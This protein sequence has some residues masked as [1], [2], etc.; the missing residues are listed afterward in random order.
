MALY[1]FM[2]AG[3]LQSITHGNSGL[4]PFIC[5]LRVAAKA[6]DWAKN[7]F[8]RRGSGGLVDLTG[9]TP[10][11]PSGDELILSIQ[12]ELSEGAT[13]ALQSRLPATPDSFTQP[14]TPSITPGPD[15]TPQPEI[16]AIAP[17]DVRLRVV[18]P[19]R[20]AIEPAPQQMEIRLHPQVPSRSQ[21]DY[22]NLKSTFTTAFK[23][24]NKTQKTLA[25][26]INVD[27]SNISE[28][29]NHNGKRQLE[30]FNKAS[31]EEQKAQQKQETELA[32]E[33]ADVRT[34]LGQ[35]MEAMKLSGDSLIERRGERKKI[36]AEEI[37]KNMDAYVDSLLDEN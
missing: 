25:H 29:P 19:S 16:S 10:A 4:K 8:D 32:R 12:A 17:P 37:R 23:V 35:V 34:S 20:P 1:L 18:E 36:V 6:L 14:C 33:L 24:I 30:G 27:R 15:F 22:A 2:K 28:A 13:P 5:N 7:E 31:V 26:P 3:E 11:S 21:L 9:T